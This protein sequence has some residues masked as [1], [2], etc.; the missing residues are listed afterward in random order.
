VG[1][2]VPA[3]DP[4]PFNVDPLDADPLAPAPFDA[5]PAMASGAANRSVP[6]V[7]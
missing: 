4:D 1:P 7:G 6:D 2:P 5:D 3:V